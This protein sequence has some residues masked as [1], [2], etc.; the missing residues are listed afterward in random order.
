MGWFS[1]IMAKRRL[2]KAKTNLA[3]RAVQF[4]RSRAN[5][6]DFSHWMCP[7]CGQILKGKE[8]RTR[9]STEMVFPPCCERYNWEGGRNFHLNIRH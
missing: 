5:A 1:D 4:N 9:A 6:S 2:A 8:V 7:A 3:H